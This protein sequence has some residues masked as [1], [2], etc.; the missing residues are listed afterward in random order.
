VRER[1]TREPAARPLLKPAA[2]HILLALGDGDS[3]GYAVMQAVRHGSGG[4]VPLSTG[5]FYRHLGKL[6]DGGLVAESAVRPTGDDPRRGTYYRLT[7]LGHR[8]LAEERQR[9]LSLVEAIDELT[10]VAQ[11]RHA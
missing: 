5:S 1:T 6:I 8:V 4:R 7:P 9:L 2:F 3:Y 11:K 10:P